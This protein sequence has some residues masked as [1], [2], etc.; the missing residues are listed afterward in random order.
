[1]RSLYKKYEAYVTLAL[2]VVLSS[3]ILWIPFTD[4]L[5][6]A[7]LHIKNHDTGTIYRNFDGPLYIIPAKTWY[8]PKE[9]KKV[10]PDNTGKPIYFAAHLPGYP[11]TIAALAPV[12]GY[13]KA[14]IASTVLATLLLTWFFYFMVKR[15]KITKHPMVLTVIM[16]FLPRF[17]VLRG[18]GT[19]EPLF[20][21]LV[22]ASLFFF[23]KKRFFWAGILG[24]LATIT[25]TPGILLF[26]AYLCAMVD[27]YRSKRVFVREWLYTMLIPAGLVG[28]FLLYLAQYGD[29]FA[30]MHTDYVVPMPYPF[31]AFNHVAQ[32]VQTGWL[33]EIVLY[34]FFYGVSIVYLKDS[35]YKS[36]FYFSLI[37]FIA[38]IFVQHRDIS[39][40]ALPMWPLALIAFE[41][42]FTTKRVVL[43]GLL[44]L[45]A[46]YLYAWNFIQINVMPIS[47][48]APFV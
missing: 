10:Y 18:V 3:V 22:L 42:F 20:V 26:V 37:F 4:L 2:V 19:P 5:S 15:M 46:V 38:L 24:A 23:E 14:M 8:N 25:K 39:R 45:P 35:P 1:M 34:L 21:L 12:L 33:E 27:E 48:W 11:A 6:F 17:L 16:L 30:Y 47:D 41:K 43:V 36:F 29:F 7:G 44:L 32:W 13:R 28:V 9:I 40:Y 31:A